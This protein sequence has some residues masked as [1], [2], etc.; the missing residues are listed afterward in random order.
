MG[1]GQ[2]IQMPQFDEDVLLRFENPS[3]STH[4]VGVDHFVWNVVCDQHL[5]PFHQQKVQALGPNYYF[6][7]DQFVHWFVYQGTEKPNFPA[8]VLFTD[9]ASVTQEGIFNSHNNHV[10]AEASPHA[11]SVHCHQQCF[12]VNVWMGIVYDFLI[13]PYLL[14]HVFLREKL[15]E[16]QEE[17]Q[18][19]LGGKTWFQHDRAAA[20]FA[21]MQRTS[22]CHLQQ[23]LDWTGRASGLASQVTDGFLPMEPH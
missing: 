1:Q 4:T 2:S 10:W 8:V 9:D 17:I 16:M 20:H 18:L 13:G 14:S 15:P 11:V 23:S 5:H 3:T 6:C 21:D 19:A 12:A 7:Q 22:H